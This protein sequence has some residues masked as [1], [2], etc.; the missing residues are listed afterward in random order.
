MPESN[1]PGNPFASPIERLLQRATV[2]SVFGAPI[3]V[4][5]VTVIPTAQIWTGFAYGSSAKAAEDAGDQAPSGGE[6]GSGGGGGL[7][8]RPTGYLRIGPD[9]VQY[10]PMFNPVVIPLAGILLSAWIVF[11]V[12]NTIRAFTGKK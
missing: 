8:S 10:E 5:D 3:Q 6:T 4:G 1:D 7:R 12:T 2:D 11:W 9:G